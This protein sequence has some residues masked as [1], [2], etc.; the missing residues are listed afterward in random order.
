MNNRFQSILTILAA[1]GIIELVS[2]GKITMLFGAKTAFFSGFSLAGPL[3]GLY[4]GL[5]FGAGLFFLRRVVHCLYMGSSL[6]SPFSFY[7]PTCAAGLYFKTSSFWIRVA[8][9]VLCMILF[10]VH[11]VGQE[12]WYYAA[13]WLIPVALYI[14]QSQTAFATA[15]GATFV[16]HAVGSVLWLYVMPTTATLWAS[17]MPIVLVERLVCAL[18]MVASIYAVSFV[19]SFKVMNPQL[20]DVNI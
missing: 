1:Y 4:S 7:L 12:A 8:V 14:A 13:Y 20:Q 18:G 2:L 17:L 16:Q 6:F 19:R 5:G 15:L 3:V 10:V 9:P 11:P